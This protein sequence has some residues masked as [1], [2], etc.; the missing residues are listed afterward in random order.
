MSSCS[1]ECQT[2]TQGTTAILDYS[3]DWLDWLNDGENVASAVWT[4]LQPSSRALP[5]QLVVNLQQQTPF[6]TK[7]WLT[8]GAAGVLYR[9]IVSMTTDALPPRTEE[10][11]F[12]VRI[13]DY[14]FSD[15]SC[16]NEQSARTC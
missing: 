1:D 13:L 5:V 2:F 4:V 7:V 14:S 9:V 16:F 10:K 12:F 8:G 15:R 3:V 11:S 6:L